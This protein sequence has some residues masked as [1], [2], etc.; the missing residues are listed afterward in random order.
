MFIVSKYQFFVEKEKEDFVKRK[1]KKKQLSVEGP[2]A[3]LSADELS[4]FY[5]EFLDKN[6]VLHANYNRY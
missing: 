4:E 2:E 1:L 3:R 6:F 5:K